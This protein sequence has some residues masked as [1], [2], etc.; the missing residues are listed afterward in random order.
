MVELS[1]SIHLGQL[2]VNFRPLYPDTIETLSEI[3]EHHSEAVWDCVWEEIQKC[4]THDVN[5]LRT[6]VKPSWADLPSTKSEEEDVTEEDKSMTCHNAVKLDK[7]VESEFSG[8]GGSNTEESAVS[9]FVIDV[10][11][12]GLIEG[13]LS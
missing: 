6:I 8:E 3:S 12:G 11:D 10:S 7:V 13:S 5:T 1:P 4:I 9:A 2:K